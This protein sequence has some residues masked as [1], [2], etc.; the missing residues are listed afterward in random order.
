[1]NLLAIEIDL[2]SFFDVNL[3]V[4]TTISFVFSVVIVSFLVFA[5]RPLNSRASIAQGKIPEKIN[6]TYIR[7]IIF[8]FAQFIAFVTDIFLVV[9]GHNYKLP[10]FTS[11][12]FLILVSY[13]MVFVLFKDFKALGY[14]AEDMLS[15]VKVASKVFKD[16]DLSALTDA[17]HTVQKSED[18][19]VVQVCQA[20]K[21]EV[22]EK[23]SEPKK[24]KI[25]YKNKT[26]GTKLPM[27]LILLLFTGSSFCLPELN[28]I[29]TVQATEQPT[30]VKGIPIE[31]IDLE[32]YE[33][34]DNILI[35]K[36][37]GKSV[38]YNL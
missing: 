17:I 5:L 21:V 16:K 35:I 25:K 38:M 12:V 29:N 14:N 7:L 31:A 18:F 9:F 10:F 20:D 27:V 19:S 6:L 30:K 28:S 32:D 15:T 26:M 3:I 23:V 8:T 34:S 2:D 37:K 1:M 24:P 11:G 4:F 36:F 13:K 33:N 22:E